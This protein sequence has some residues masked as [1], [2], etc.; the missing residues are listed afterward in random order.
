MKCTAARHARLMHCR[1]G[2]VVCGI[3]LTFLHISS[4]FLY[5][6]LVG[7]CHGKGGG[8]EGHSKRT[9]EWHC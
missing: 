2:S 3:R 5:V 4:A 6:S 1:K 7:S 8:G 9:G